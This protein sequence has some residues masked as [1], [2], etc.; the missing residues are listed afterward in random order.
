MPL[1]LDEIHKGHDRSQ[2]NDVYRGRYFPENR[3]LAGIRAW[4]QS[5]YIS[6]ASN[7]TC[8]QSVSS[9]PS[10]APV[11]SV[12]A[13]VVCPGRGSRILACQLGSASCRTRLLLLFAQHVPVILCP[14]P[15][16]SLVSREERV[17][18]PVL[19]LGTCGSKPF[20]TWSSPP[21]RIPKQDKPARY[22]HYYSVLRELEK[23]GA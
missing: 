3:Y 22:G 4:S 17:W 1:A 6:P 5:R 11:P 9:R 7:N 2:E 15:V 13:S 21:N 20:S 12:N 16:P 14:S 8:Q 19:L 18:S 10:D 23:S